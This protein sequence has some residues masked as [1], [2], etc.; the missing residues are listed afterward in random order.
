MSDNQLIFTRHGNIVAIALPPT[1]ACGNAGDIIGEI[2]RD[3]NSDEWE[4]FAAAGIDWLPAGDSALAVRQ[5]AADAAYQRHL[6]FI[7]DGDGEAFVLYARFTGAKAPRD[8]ILRVAADGAHSAV[9]QDD[10][11]AYLIRRQAV[12]MCE[13]LN[14]GR[15]VRINGIGDDVALRAD[16]Q[17]APTRYEVRS[18]THRG[19][20]HTESYHR[21]HRPPAAQSLTRFHTL[22]PVKPDDRSA[23]F[24]PYTLADGTP[25]RRRPAK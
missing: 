12:E 3:G 8:T 4:I 18:M 1:A 16:W 10:I 13:A 6:K 23:S 22:A 7:A 14:A 17:D 11:L 2:H 20:R 21:H 19:I 25:L 15:P 24:G 9:E 5:T